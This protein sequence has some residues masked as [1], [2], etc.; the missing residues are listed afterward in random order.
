MF[1]RQNCL[2][3]V[4]EIGCTFLICCSLRASAVIMFCKHPTGLIV[5]DAKHLASATLTRQHSL[6]R[7]STKSCLPSSSS[8]L[9]M[10]ASKRCGTTTALT[11]TCCATMALT[12]EALLPT[13]C[14]WL[15][16]GTH[17]GRARVTAWKASQGTHS[18][19]CTGF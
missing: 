3:C 15:A 8:F 12:A 1:T 10:P 5:P 6:C 11:A 13:R 9:R 14:T 2:I 19:V 18:A 4:C 17:P 16:C 7:K